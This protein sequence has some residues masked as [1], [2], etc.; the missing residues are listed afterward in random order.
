VHQRK[1]FLLVYLILCLT[2]ITLL[3]VSGCGKGAQEEKQAIPRT[4]QEAGIETL[5]SSSCEGCHLSPEV[6]SSFK[7]PKT[8][9]TTQSEG[10]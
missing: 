5:D 2:G 10:G 3:L 8:E 6:I 4:P 7:K 9:A 1:R